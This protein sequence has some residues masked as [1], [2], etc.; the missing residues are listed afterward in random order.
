LSVKIRLKRTGTT[1]CPCWRVVVAD[2]RS[3]RDSRCI[4]EIGYYNPKSDPA[5]LVMKQD[6]VQYWLGVGAQPSVQVKSLI[7]KMK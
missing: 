3:P 2:S 1:N 6:R 7:A 4:E 5:E